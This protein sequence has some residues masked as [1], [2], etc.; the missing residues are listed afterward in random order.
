[1]KGPFVRFP[2]SI[3]TLGVVAMLLSGCI[4]RDR[5]DSATPYNTT[6]AADAAPTTESSPKPVE[7]LDPETEPTTE[8]E[9][10]ATTYEPK[11]PETAETTPE[12][13]RTRTAM[14]GVT[15]IVPVNTVQLSCRHAGRLPSLA[16][17]NGNDYPRIVFNA[18]CASE[19]SGNRVS[20]TFGQVGANEGVECGTQYYING[21]NPKGIAWWCPKLEMLI[22]SPAAVLDSS[23]TQR[24]RE[25]T[26][27][28]SMAVAQTK[29]SKAH[30]TNKIV[31]V[32]GR[33]VKNLKDKSKLTAAQA[34]A[35]KD[36]LNGLFANNGAPALSKLFLKA[37]K[38][39]TC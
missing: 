2:R 24:L 35:L 38:T 29:Y 20:F 6:V 18:M 32:M 37:Y 31:C 19:S 14:P 16:S 23:N 7:T 5:T 39:G 3:A 34:V 28:Y 10:D 1:M 8:A 15:I 12:A 17:T 21:D 22:S 9:P 33:T 27:A 13:I 30:D 11:E 4:G 25:L 36:D 26:I